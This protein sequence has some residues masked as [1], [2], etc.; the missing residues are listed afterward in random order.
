MSLPPVRCLYGTGGRTVFFRIILCEMCLFLPLISAVSDRGYRYR[1]NA[2]EQG[3]DPNG[4]S[5]DVRPPSG[6]WVL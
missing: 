4:H 5:V 2:E 3:P 1:E 6:P